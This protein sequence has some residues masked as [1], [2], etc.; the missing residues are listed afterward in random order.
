[1][2]TKIIDNKI[3]ME[4]EDSEEERLFAELKEKNFFSTYYVLSVSKRILLFTPVAGD[5]KEGAKNC[6]KSTTK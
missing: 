5:K 6:E 2:I 3:Q 4:T 1:M